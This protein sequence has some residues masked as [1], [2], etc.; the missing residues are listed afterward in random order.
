M[1]S[2]AVTRNCRALGVEKLP[3]TRVAPSLVSISLPNKGL[4]HSGTTSNWW[5][6]ICQSQ[7][8]RSAR[9]TLLVGAFPVA[10]KMVQVWEEKFTTRYGTRG[11][12]DEPTK[13]NWL[14]LSSEIPLSFQ[15]RNNIPSGRTTA[16]LINKFLACGL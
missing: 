10:P 1:G 13:V 12:L 16:F 6:N 14:S 11:L 15:T 4:R 3:I 2:S 7:Q 5:E 8:Q 9:V